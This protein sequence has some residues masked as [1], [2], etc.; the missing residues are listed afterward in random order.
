MNVT[1]RPIEQ[2]PGKP[3]RNR[4]RSRFGSRQN[5]ATQ[6]AALGVVRDELRHLGAREV[7][8]QLAL[9]ESDIRLDGWPRSNARSPEH[10]GV[11]ISFESRHGPLEY[12]TDRYSRWECNL[13][14]IGRSLEALR[15]VDRYGVSGAGQQYTGWKK[16][17]ATSTPTAETVLAKWS[18]FAH[19]QVRREP[20]AAYRKAARA[21]HPDV[22]GSHED[23]HA[24]NEAARALG[25]A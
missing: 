12:A 23:F 14:A 15:K 19:D 25:V 24:V 9:R 4:Q 6:S 13:Y 20:R 18:G 1:F 7:V 10:P 3:T 16:I 17:G 21:T 2:W 8:V 5:G 22:G 11:I